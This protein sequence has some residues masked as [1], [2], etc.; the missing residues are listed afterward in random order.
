VIPT[1][2]GPDAEKAYGLAAKI[3]QQSKLEIILLHVVSDVLFQLQNWVFVDVPVVM[4]ARQHQDFEKDLHKEL[5]KAVSFEVF[6][7]VKVSTKVLNIGHGDP[8]KAIL[9]YL[10]SKEH[11]LVIM[12]T[13]GDDFGGDSNAEKIARKS[14]IPVLTTKIY[15]LEWGGETI[16]M[17]TDFKTVNKRFIKGL[18]D[19]AS[20]LNMKMVFAYINTPKHFKDTI[21][22]EKEWG[23][24]AQKFALRGSEFIVFNDKH[25]EDGVKKL[26]TKLSP[27][28]VALPTHG[29]TGFDHFLY[30]SYT[31]DLINEL[32]VPVY[33]YNMKND[34]HSKSYRTV[35]ETR[36]FT[37]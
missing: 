8:V 22:I 21:S 12:G 5:D 24:F 31:E 11:S 26:V 35:V 30:G 34:Y 19:I 33:S 36:G 10:N 29:L 27:H 37:G 18:V 4:D 15:D 13:S 9:N 20:W 16:L 1:D 14:V 17:P 25:I 23:R 32:E 2:F 7:D 28:I 6:K 3:A